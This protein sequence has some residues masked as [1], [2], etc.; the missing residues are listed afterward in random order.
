MKKQV[1]YRVIVGKN[2]PSS[3]YVLDDFFHYAPHH[4]EG[5]FYSLIKEYMND[6]W[7]CQGEFKARG[8]WRYQTMVKYED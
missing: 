3:S 5:G 1:D 2:G 7:V 4:G 6:G 8:D